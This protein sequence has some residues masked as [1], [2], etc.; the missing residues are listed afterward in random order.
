MSKIL[1]L[2]DRL[3]D[4][5]IKKEY[6]KTYMQNTFYTGLLESTL[7][8]AFLKAGL[9]YTALEHAAKIQQLFAN[10]DLPG[11]GPVSTVLCIIALCDTHLTLSKWKELEN[12]I[13]YVND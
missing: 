12:D 8:R 13:A 6:T 10:S 3:Q 5:Q 7:T 4:P 1:Q 9:H 2:C 11:I